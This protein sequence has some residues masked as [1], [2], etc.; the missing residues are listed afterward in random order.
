[1]RDCY[2]TTMK[3]AQEYNDWMIEFARI[4]VNAAFDSAQELCG[5]KSAL[6]KEGV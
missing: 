5:L 2:L 4:N 6:D 3:G 1:M